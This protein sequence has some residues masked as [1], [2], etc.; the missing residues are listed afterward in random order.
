MAKTKKLPEKVGNYHFFKK[1]GNTCCVTGV[2]LGET[3]GYALDLD[4]MQIGTVYE[5]EALLKSGLV[6][7]IALTKL[8]PKTVEALAKIKITKVKQL[9]NMWHN[10]TPFASLVGIGEAHAEAIESYFWFDKEVV[11]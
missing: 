2:H 8:D 5:Y 1:I 11:K 4:R 6:E 7:E 3:G 9:Q 10:S